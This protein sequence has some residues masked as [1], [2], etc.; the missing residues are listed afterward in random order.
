MTA[1]GSSTLDRLLNDRPSKHFSRLLLSPVPA[2]PRP[3]PI[4]MPLVHEGIN[5]DL[6]TLLDVAV[7]DEEDT[8]PLRHVRV[9]RKHSDATASSLQIRDFTDQPSHHHH[10]GTHSVADE[11][12]LLSTS[13]NHQSSISR[14]S[15]PAHLEVVSQQQPVPNRVVF[16]HRT[17][18]QHLT[19]TKVRNLEHQLAKLKFEMAEAQS[20]ADWYK[21]Q[22][23]QLHIEYEDLQSFCKQLHAENADLRSS[24]ARTFKRR[25]KW[26]KSERLKHL[27]RSRRRTSYTETMRKPK[28][29]ATAPDT[30]VPNSIDEN[31][32][33]LT[34]SAH[35]DETLASTV[36]FDTS[37]KADDTSTA[38]KI[39]GAWQDRLNRSLQDFME[40]STKSGDD[41]SVLSE[42]SE[43]SPYMFEKRTDQSGEPPIE[44]DKPHDIT[45]KQGP[46]WVQPHRTQFSKRQSLETENDLFEELLGDD[47]YDSVSTPE[48]VEPMWDVGA[49][50]PTSKKTNE[51]NGAGSF[52]E[53][54]SV[55]KESGPF[56]PELTTMH[57]KTRQEVGTTQREKDTLPEEDSSIDLD[58]SDASLDPGP[59]E[60]IHTVD[61]PPSHTDLLIPMNRCQPRR[62]SSTLE[63]SRA[64]EILQ[65]FTDL[66]VSDDE[67]DD[68]TP[69][70]GRFS[71]VAVNQGSS[72]SQKSSSWW[73]ES[74][75]RSLPMNRRL[76]KAKARLEISLGIGLSANEAVGDR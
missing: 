22:N 6:N 18:S 16:Q 15:A 51:E 5:S 13:L 40:G 61:E 21:L 36:G 20:R 7:C 35:D 42:R 56:V 63:D 60:T 76:R 52:L 1:N 33:N 17:T 69:A 3:S 57:M 10:V 12:S 72:S 50:V 11:E 9:G 67:C 65:G 14:M 28:P 74:R 37:S 31:S 29:K 66:N 73:G 41:M 54:T 44:D 59:L 32:I 30:Q 64:S 8:N 75:R 68:G 43:V 23:R 70:N 71:E 26:F 38:S 62:Q 47:D 55:E 27:T 48:D 46:Q 58:A 39:S 34:Q 49:E 2:A 19:S 4:T 25:P 45:F 53:K 24:G